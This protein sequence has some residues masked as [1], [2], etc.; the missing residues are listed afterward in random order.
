MGG[1]VDLDGLRIAIR[2]GYSAHA[3]QKSLLNFATRMRHWPKEICLVHGE[4]NARRHLAGFCNNAM[5][6]TARP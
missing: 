1:Y 5:P 4:A 2:P 3:D 6:R